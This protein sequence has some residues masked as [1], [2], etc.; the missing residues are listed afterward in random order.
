MH[1]ANSAEQVTPLAL[2]TSVPDVTIKTTDGASI[3]LAKVL[4]K[5][6]AVILFYRGGW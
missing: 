1:V 4:D 5:K 3:S 2:G 6:P